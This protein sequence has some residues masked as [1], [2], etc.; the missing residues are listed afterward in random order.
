MAAQPNRR[1]L[2]AQLCLFAVVMICAANSTAAGVFTRGSVTGGNIN[3]GLFQA[4][5]SPAV[6]LQ[7]TGPYRSDDPISPGSVTS[8]GGVYGDWNAS[9]VWDGITGGSMLS[10]TPGG[11]LRGVSPTLSLAA[12]TGIQYFTNNGDPTLVMTLDYAFSG[13]VAPG[14]SIFWSVGANEHEPN[15]GGNFVEIDYSGTISQSGAFSFSDHQTRLWN[16]ANPV[17]TVF[18]QNLSVRVSITPGVND[19]GAASWIAIDPSVGTSQDPNYQ[20]PSDNP[21]VVPEPSSLLVFR[22]LG[23]VAA[24]GVAIRR[25]RGK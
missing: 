19:S 12:T 25:R 4:P 24:S 9:A 7:S 15:F 5:T 1:I 18:Q 2:A 23:F 14:D 20:F 8:I 17:A 22:G 11:Q 16:Q 6:Q 10:V 13:Y 3:G 21:A